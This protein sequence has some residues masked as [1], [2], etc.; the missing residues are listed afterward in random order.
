MRPPE[1]A[2]AVLS[3]DVDALPDAIGDT[4]RYEGAVVL[5]RVGGQPAGQ[6]LF[7]F[8]HDPAASSLRSQLLEH[9]DSAVWEALVRH[10]L[11][12]PAEGP[13][14]ASL[15]QATVAICT[16]DRTEDLERCLD[17]LLAMSD[18]A[19]IVVVDNAPSTEDTR[20]LVERYPSVGYLRE[21]RRGLN[22]ARNAALSAIT[23]EVI[24]F[25]DDDAV[26]DRDW[27]GT[28]LRNFDDPT[29]LAA[30]GATMA[31]EL[32]TQ[33]QI[34]FQRMGGF[35]RGL[36]RKVYDRTNCDPYE[37]WHAGAGVNMAVR[38]SIRECIGLFDPALDAGTP[39]LAG[40]D[41]DLF[42]RILQRG[43]RI[44]YD[45]RAVNWHRHRR[46]MDELRQQIFG[47]EVAA[48]AMYTKGLL[49]EGDP[50]AV[51][52]VAKWLKKEIPQMLRSWRNRDHGELPFTPAATRA[53]GALAGPL[54]YL[55]ARRAARNG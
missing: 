4:E 14:P 12:L 19:P 51:V 46:S 1:V 15:P 2:I 44:A 34:A 38:R 31:L 35:T 42:R 55:Q 17:G 32:E 33:A 30:T 21:P 36:K 53:R 48:F 6:S 28:L 25:I 50:A 27:L 43:Y 13:N 8:P 26:P 41:T 29:V 10:S 54:R 45:P 52:A 16:R 18:K 37:A 49:F 23:T 24:A 39:A 47:Y 9:A 5:L 3:L 11:G 20:L 40:G 7:R 22:N